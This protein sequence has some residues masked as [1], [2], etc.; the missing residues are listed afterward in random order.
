MQ[1][2]PSL[3]IISVTGHSGYTRGSMFAIHCS[4]LALKDKIADLRCVLISPER[5]ADLPEQIR[6]IQCAQMTHKEY[7]AFSFLALG[8]FVDTD[9]ALLVQNDGWVLHG[10]VWT[11]EFFQYDYI[12]APVCH[13]Y[14]NNEVM[15]TEL[16]KQNFSIPAPEGMLEMFN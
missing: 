2:Q 4:Y 6:H 11:D 13:Y 7:N 5:P 9:F 16:W 8:Q 14:D 12:G 3:T 1:S 10:D 15:S